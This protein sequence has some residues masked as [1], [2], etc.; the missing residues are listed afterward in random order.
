MY[1]TYRPAL[2]ALLVLS[3]SSTLLGQPKA[4]RV[5]RRPTANAPANSSRSVS[6]PADDTG[7]VYVLDGM[8]MLLSLHH[9]TEVGTNK[10]VDVWALVIEMQVMNS[11][12][13]LEPEGLQIF[14]FFTRFP[15]DVKNDVNPHTAHDC[16][17]WAGLVTEAMQNRDP[18]SKT[19]PYIE[20]QTAVGARVLQTNEDGAVWWADDVQ[21]WGSS[22]RFP[23][24]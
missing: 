24:F 6:K 8:P 22:D 20:F 4:T 9:D 13:D 1:G 19:W 17:I 10:P 11:D 16:K 3:M 21:C 14:N 5:E 2:L 12:G 18:K 7:A 23:P 15:R